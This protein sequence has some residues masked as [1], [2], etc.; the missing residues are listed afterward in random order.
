MRI[1]CPNSGFC[2]RQLSWTT[3]LLMC[4]GWGQPPG[5][6]WRG[7]EDLNITC[8]TPKSHVLDKNIEFGMTCAKSTPSSPFLTTQ[9]I[10]LRL[11]VHVVYHPPFEGYLVLKSSTYFPSDVDA[12]AVGAHT[13]TNTLRLG[14]ILRF[15]F[16]ET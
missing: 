10:S 7:G 3:F 6:R 13:D 2:P 16:L 4:L 9:P 15:D 5:R 8:I 1:L 11:C 14:L 12:G